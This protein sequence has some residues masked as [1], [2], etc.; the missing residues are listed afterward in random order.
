[1]DRRKRG[2]AFVAAW[3]TTHRTRTESS[4]AR[5][6]TARTSNTCCQVSLRKNP[7]A[8]SSSLI[9]LSLHVER[10]RAR[11]GR[12]C[13]VRKPARKMDIDIPR[14][15]G[16]FDTRSLPLFPNSSR[17]DSRWYLAERRR[18]YCQ[19]VA[20]PRSGVSG[21][22]A[23]QPSCRW[24]RRECDSGFDDSLCGNQ[25]LTEFEYSVQL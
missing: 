18:F 13:P 24:V 8:L 5:R 9:S 22:A 15:N 20:E 17:T 14:S 21:R 7:Q 12:H 23:G 16:R 19:G 2:G 1:M 6:S 25:I 11:F 4:L 10:N 3:R